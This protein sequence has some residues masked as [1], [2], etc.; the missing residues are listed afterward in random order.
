MRQQ[1]RGEEGAGGKQQQASELRVR[2]R[3]EDDKE[4]DRGQGRTGLKIAG[5]KGCW[6]ALSSQT[7]FGTI[8]DATLG[9]IYPVWASHLQADVEAEP[10]MQPRELRLP[11]DPP[12]KEVMLSRVQ[13]E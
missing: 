5:M 9:Q 12:A 10:Y 7:G 8:H 11:K 4:V 3:A 13:R 2:G 1:V 6:L